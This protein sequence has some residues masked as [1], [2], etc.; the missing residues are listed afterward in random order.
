[1]N[2]LRHFLCACDSNIFLTSY[3]NQIRPIDIHF[4]K[5]K[6][7]ILNSM[8]FQ[9]LIY[10]IIY[11]SSQKFPTPVI[12]RYFLLHT[13]QIKTNKGQD[14]LSV[15]ENYI[16]YSILFY[17][18]FYPIIYILTILYKSSHTFPTLVIQRYFL[19]LTLQI[20]TK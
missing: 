7:Y 6:N 5:T 13:L 2:P 16:L 18:L 9:I 8:L 19:L 15:H 17:I 4:H 11:I 10:P 3:I 20:K 1:M 14:I 12:Q